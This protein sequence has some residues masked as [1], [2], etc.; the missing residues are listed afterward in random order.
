MSQKK[1]FLLDGMALVY[2]AFFAF[3]QNPRIASNGLNTSAM[4]GFVNT[5]LDVIRN[6][7]PTHLACVFDTAEPTERHIVYEQYKAHRRYRS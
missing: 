2:R 6:Q 5:L 3:S 1:L 7:N 4:F